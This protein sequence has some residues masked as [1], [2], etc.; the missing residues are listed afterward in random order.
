MQADVGIPAQSFDL[1]AHL[2]RQREFSERTFGPGDRA[3]GV[4]DHI[5]KELLEITADPRDLTEWVDV[6]L[7]A[8]DGAWRAGFSP[9]EIAKAIAEKQARNEQRH[10][11]DWRTASPGKAIEHIR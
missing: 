7:L 8:L 1:V 9:E 3:L 10:W 2:Y 11:P 5:R 6:V 4:V